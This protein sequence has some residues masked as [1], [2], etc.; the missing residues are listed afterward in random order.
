[1]QK[2]IPHLWFDNQAEEAVNFYTSIFKEG[3]IHRAVRYPEAGKEIHGREPGSVMS[4][5]FEIC[6]YKFLALNGGPVFTFTPAISFMVNLKTK[7]EVDEL[8]DKLSVG[9]QALMPLDAYPFNER[10]G[11]MQDKFGLSWQLMFNPD[12]VEPIVPSLL[13][14]QEKAGKAEEAIN[15]YAS[16]FQNAHIGEVARYGAN[17]APD[18][19]G[20]LMY[21]S[22]TLE[23]Q[24]FAAMDSAHDHTFTF[25]EAVSLMVM[26]HNQQ[27][28]DSLWEKLSAVPESEQCGWLKDKYGVSWQIV[29]PGMEAFLGGEDKEKSNRAMTAMLQMK[30]IDIQKLKEAYEGAS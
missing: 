28:I 6:G 25:N 14:T 13:F 16:V 18:K 1:M 7:E 22:F 8:W 10:Y 21:A 23:G 27:E 2:I 3:K 9:G 12:Q 20:T 24:K 30:K 17:Q 4:V 11:W 5:E 29:P 15:F 19:E 26:C